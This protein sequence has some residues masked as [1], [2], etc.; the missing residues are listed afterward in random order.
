MA[1]YKHF[2]VERRPDTAVLRVKDARLFDTLTV[3]ELEDDLL[4]FLEDEMP[5]HLVISFAP[6]INGSTAVINGLLRVKKRLVPAGGSL[7]LCDMAPVIRDAY[8][9][10]NLDGTVFQIVTSVSEALKQIAVRQTSS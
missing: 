5:R 4:N 9:L 10:L 2:D 6:V 3:N 1:S 7:W 8:Q